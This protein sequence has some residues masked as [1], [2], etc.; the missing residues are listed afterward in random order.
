MTTGDPFHTPPPP[1]GVVR[2]DAL[3]VYWAARVEDLGALAREGPRSQNFVT[4]QAQWDGVKAALDADDLAALLSMGQGSSAVIGKLLSEAVYERVRLRVLPG[5]PSRLSCLFAALSAPDAVAFASRSGTSTAF[6][7]QTGFAVNGKMGVPART[8]G[9]WVAL[10]MNGCQAYAI[11]PD[12]AS[13]AQL[14][15]GLERVAEAYW[16]GQTTAEPFIEILAERLAVDGWAP[17]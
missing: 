1:L 10:D 15:A 5:A 6:D 17:S 7:P 13:L 9:A 12:G 4:G 2:S 8:S 11:P 16:N 14:I 3:P